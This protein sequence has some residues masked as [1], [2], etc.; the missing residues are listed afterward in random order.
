MYFAGYFWSKMKSEKG[1]KPLKMPHWTLY[2][3]LAFCGIIFIVAPATDMIGSAQFC[4]WMAA[5][6]LLIYMGRDNELERRLCK[7]EKNNK[8]N[9]NMGA[10]KNE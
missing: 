1:E 6:M 4:G 8:K 5:A 3:I 9:N 7:I 10:V 2:I